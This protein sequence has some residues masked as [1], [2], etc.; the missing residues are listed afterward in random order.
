MRRDD[1]A[2]PACEIIQD[3]ANYSIYYLFVRYIHGSVQC[4]ELITLVDDVIHF[5]SLIPETCEAIKRP[6]SLPHFN[7]PPSTA[8]SDKAKHSV[9]PSADGREVVEANHAIKVAPG[10]PIEVICAGLSKVRV[11]YACVYAWLMWCVVE[12]RL[13]RCLYFEHWSSW[14]T[15]AIT[16]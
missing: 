3:A 11:K 15:S 7:S 1:T 13:G 12:N 9:I 8:M 14:A 4:K 10:S 2:W 16:W 6:S 5:P